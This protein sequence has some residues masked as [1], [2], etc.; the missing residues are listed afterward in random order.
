MYNFTIAIREGRVLKTIFKNFYSALIFLAVF[1]S[2]HSKVKETAG[3]TDP[4]RLRVTFAVLGDTHG[5]AVE[6]SSFANAV[7][8]M[9][10]L[11]VSFIVGLGDNLEDPKNTRKTHDTFLDWVREQPFW[12]VHFW[13]TVAD[14]ENEYFG[15]GSGDW[16]AGRGLIDFFGVPYRPDVVMAE[17]EHPVKPPVSYYVPIRI[18]EVTVHLI[19]LTF[20]DTPKGNPIIPF[21]E[22]TRAFMERILRTINKDGNDIVVIGAHSETGTWIDVLSGARQALIRRQCDLALSGTTH[23]YKRTDH[24]PTGPLALT[25]GFCF[26]K[27]HDPDQS[28]YGWIAVY[29]F[30]DPLCLMTVYVNPNTHNMVLPRY[31]GWWETG[32]G[33]HLTYVKF[34][35]SGHIVPVAFENAGK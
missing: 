18:G 6:D 27:V 22:E 11:Q 25:N 34:L 12:M 14:G 7:R 23:D 29:V 13:P 4:E 3:L 15:T 1:C 10:D 32:K 35:E 24:G 28:D 33:N 20:S 8:Q 9:E 31:D 5:N 21:R 19:Q 16:G 30:S 2:P 26:D 17:G